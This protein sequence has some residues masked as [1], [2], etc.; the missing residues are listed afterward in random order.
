M[1]G[2]YEYVKGICR[3]RRSILRRKCN[4]ICILSCMAEIQEAGIENTCSAWLIV[5][6]RLISSQKA[7]VGKIYVLCILGS[8]DCQVGLTFTLDKHSFE[9]LHDEQEYYY[10]VCSTHLWSTSFF[11]CCKGWLVINRCNKCSNSNH[12][13]PNICEQRHPLIAC[14]RK[15]F[16]TQWDIPRPT[17]HTSLLI[18]LTM[19]SKGDMERIYEVT[20]N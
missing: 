8:K 3:V 7:T 10:P 9:K 16:L 12:R 2:R 18:S 1:T 17:P 20:K 11:L 15:D 19:V 4:G 13:K 6:I 14:I 5:R